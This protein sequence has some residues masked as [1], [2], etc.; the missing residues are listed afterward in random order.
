MS[1]IFVALNIIY[2]LILIFILILALANFI[3]IFDFKEFFY[4]IYFFVFFLIFNFIFAIK[5][6]YQITL[7]LI[8]IN[9]YF[10]LNYFFFIL[11]ITFL[12]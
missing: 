11:L 10:K 8:P 5:K 12:N 9:S 1:Y 3:E 2:R 4:M 7:Q 6:N